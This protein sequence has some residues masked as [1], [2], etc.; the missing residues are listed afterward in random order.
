SEFRRCQHAGEPHC[1]GE[2]CSRGRGIPISEG[3]IRI[4]SAPL[5]ACGHYLTPGHF[6]RSLG[7]RKSPPIARRVRG[8]R[9]RIRSWPRRSADMNGDACTMTVLSLA[10]EVNRQVVVAEAPVGGKRDLVRPVSVH[11][12]VAEFAFTVDQGRLRNGRRPSS[13]LLAANGGRT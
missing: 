7:S 3:L 11:H 12:R 4:C 8:G 6:G 10:E 13:T 1:V 5:F 2:L 9:S